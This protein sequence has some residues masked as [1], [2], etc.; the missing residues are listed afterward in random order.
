MHT[1]LAAMQMPW[2]SLAFDI[3]GEAAVLVLACHL[4]VLVVAVAT[5]H[6]S[7]GRIA[8]RFTLLRSLEIAMGV[9]WEGLRDGW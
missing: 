6:T 3:D 4:P 1:P 7:T 5:L 2:F 8:G 9:A